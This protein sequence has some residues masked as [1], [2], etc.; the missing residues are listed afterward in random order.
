[1]LYNYSVKK[2]NKHHK[3]YTKISGNYQLSLPL[4]FETFIPEDDSVRLL[5]HI[6]E[7][8]NYKKLYQAYS[9]TGRKPVVEPKVL[10][11][12]ITY[13][14][15]NGIYS[16]RKIERA[17]K[18]DINFL[19]LLQGYKAPDHSTIARFIKEFLET[20][21]EDLFN[22]MVF[23]LHEI[24]EIEFKNL[25][26]DGTK[27][28]ANAN[29]YTFVWKKVINKN[30][31][32]MLIKIEALFNEIGSHYLTDII[33]DNKDI[34]KS[35]DALLIFLKNKQTEENI[36]FVHGTGKR[37]SKLQKF[38]E[39]A[40][41]F[42]ERQQKYNKAN[43]IFNGRNSYSKTDS[44][45]TFMHMKEDHMRNAQLKPGYNIQ[46][47]VESEY[48]TGVDIFSDR[49]DV[50]TLIPFLENMHNKLGRRY[51]NIIADAGYESEENYLYLAE[52]KQRAYIKP[53]MYEKW[54]KTSFKKDISK[55][56]NMA[57]TEDE[58]YYICHN[59]KRL[60]P[61]GIT[62][63]KSSSGYEAE[64][65]IYECEDC[66]DCPYKL[67]CTK[68]KGNRKMHVSKTFVAKR[69]V[70]HQNIKTDQGILLRMN[71]S[72]QVEGA[73]GVL[74]SD[75]GFNRFLRRGKNNVKNEFILLCLA[76]NI[77]KLHSKIQK[78]RCEKH[79]HPLKTA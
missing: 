35:L 16:T 13:A 65:T 46:I 7:G 58:D 52:K 29:K 14:F 4:D 5:S 20:A 27:L 11:K 76:Y 36:V 74:K 59:K 19:W 48:I 79:L 49:S 51:E 9:S 68:A 2:I 72:I 64:L 61:V 63:K 41:E 78:G 43:S 37:K 39:T 26:V 28:E 21:M 34:I 75:Y 57:Y 24:N 38:F 67:K 53:Q 66:N 54:K 25:F 73:F 71:R 47:G 17:C 42:H 62:H 3:Q 50:T 77:N 1:M 32:K 30:E 40:T 44:D 69:E 45:A 55:R 15:M 60:N 6:L 33:F 18:R 10:F 31:A 22:Q 70:S 8:L 12:V 23:Y 56:E